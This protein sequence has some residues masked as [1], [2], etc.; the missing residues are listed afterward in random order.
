LTKASDA[1]PA[2][3]IVAAVLGIVIT[4]A[5]IAGDKTEMA[6]MSRTRWWEPSSACC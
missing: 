5:S 6:T 2:I 1:L 4:M 3:G